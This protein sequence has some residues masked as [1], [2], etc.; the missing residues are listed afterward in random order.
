MTDKTD[1]ATTPTGTFTRAA[2]AAVS[3]VEGT[4][5]HT[6]ADRPARGG[7]QD[8]PSPAAA[9]V[10]TRAE[11][12]L[13]FSVIICAYTEKRWSDLVKAVESLRQQT[14]AP[15]EVIL[16][17]DH[18]PALLALVQ[19]EMPDVIAVENQEENGLSGARNSGVAA[20]SGE[21]IAF[22]DDDAVAA[23]NWL[24][25]LLQ[26]YADPQ[27]V[28]VGGASLPIWVHHHPA[29]FPEEFNWV[30]GCSYRGMPVTT[31]TVRNLIG[32][33]MSFRREVFEA[34]GGFRNGIGRVNTRPVGCEETELCIRANQHWPDRAIRYK[35]DARVFHHVPGNRTSWRYFFARCYFEGIAKAFVSRYTGAKDGLASEWTYSL[36]TLPA[37]VLRG[38]AHTAVNFDPVGLVRAGAIVAGLGVTATGYLVGKV[39][40]AT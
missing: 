11:P 13:G 7:Q 20:A 22:L 27:V 40:K 24:E 17:V 35:P 19:S 9:A 10:R 37:G 8:E 34:V 2:S 3:T 31:A 25:E 18:N 5:L 6:A 14:V 36:Q 16:V 21:I 33:N 15:D 26:E 29:W 32:C 30:V 39:A 1:K 12:R 38:L 23:P 28:G 4:A